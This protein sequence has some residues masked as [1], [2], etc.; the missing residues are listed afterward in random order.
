MMKC[1]IGLGM[2]R[3]ITTASSQEARDVG[4]LFPQYLEL[5]VLSSNT[6]VLQLNE[7]R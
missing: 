2:R 7:Y 3:H 5:C 4:V 6:T 1:G